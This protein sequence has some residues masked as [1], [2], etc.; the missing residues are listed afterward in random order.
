MLSEWIFYS[1]ATL[2]Y[3][4]LSYA[5]ILNIDVFYY[6]ID[7]YSHF[8]KVT[9]LSVPN[10]LIR[11]SLSAGKIL[12]SKLL[13]QVFPYANVFMKV[14]ILSLAMNT[15]TDSSCGQKLTLSIAA[16]EKLSAC[17]YLRLN[18]Y[19]L[20]SNLSYKISVP[21]KE[22]LVHF[23]TQHTANAFLEENHHKAEV[24][25]ENVPFYRPEY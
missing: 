20:C 23:T 17:K 8:F 15:V 5:D 9:C 12:N 19:S 21:W 24:L 18:N 3:I 11:K 25:S 14:R 13:I 7:F 1:W 6:T 10:S 16:H 2:A 4:A 22:R